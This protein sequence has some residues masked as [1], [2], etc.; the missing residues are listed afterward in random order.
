MKR[1]ARMRIKSFA[2][3]EE[4]RHKLLVMFY[5]NLPASG[6]IYVFLPEV[7]LK[8]IGICTFISILLTHHRSENC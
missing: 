4:G 2:A 3:L 8:H 1:R 6:C 5:S 7:A